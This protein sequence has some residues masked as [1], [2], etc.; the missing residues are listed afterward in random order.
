MR[1]P[2]IVGSLFIT[3]ALVLAGGC[4][5]DATRGAE[6][7]TRGAVGGM[8]GAAGG[9]GG[10]PGKLQCT[11]LLEGPGMSS[12]PKRCCP[13]PH[14]DCSDKPDGYTEPGETGTCVNAPPGGASYCSCECVGGA[15]WCGC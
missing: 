10:G 1:A 4:G 5:Q 3:A 11:D 12:G 14:P 8:S 13:Q 6:G 7:G 2:Q 9:D 15:W